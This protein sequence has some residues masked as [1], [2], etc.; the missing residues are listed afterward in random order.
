MKTIKTYALISLMCAVPAC[1]TQ[2]VEF[3][4]AAVRN[5]GGVVDAP[6]TDARIDALAVDALTRDAPTPDAAIPDAAMP[7]APAIDARLVDSALP[8]MVVRDAAL[9]DADQPDLGRPD[10]AEASPCRQDPVA[11]GAVGDYAVMAGATVTNTGLSFV[12]GDLGVSPGTAVTGFPPGTLVGAQHAGVSQSALG[13]AAL[14]IAYNDAAGRT[15]CPV[16]LAGNVGGQTLPPGLY[17]S[18]SSLEVTSG[19]L[20]LDGKGDANAIFIF[21]IATTF[22]LGPARKVFLI[23]EAKAA[24]VYWQVGTSATFDSTS[25]LVG[26]VMAD[27]SITLKT[28][29]RLDGRAL[30]RIAAVTLDTSTVIKPLP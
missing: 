18:T 9:V 29:A 10:V 17:K 26:T 1:G 28:G 3:G 22:E 21:Q 19:D 13:M 25:V 12:T 24:N 30:A 8:D 16:G 15:L 7:D 27:Q 14:T 5:D 11:L 23:G 4:D 6:M 20:T 2:L